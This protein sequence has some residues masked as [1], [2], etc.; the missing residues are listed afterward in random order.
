MLEDLIKKHRRLEFIWDERGKKFWCT[1]GWVSMDN[2]L[3]VTGA[4]LKASQR[5]AERD[6]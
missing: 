6:R 2:D 5:A 3:T 1:V 4:A